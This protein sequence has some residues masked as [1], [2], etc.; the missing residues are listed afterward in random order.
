MKVYLCAG[1]KHSYIIAKRRG[2]GV[3]VSYFQMMSEKQFE[4]LLITWFKTGSK[5]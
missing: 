4:K 3:L 5:K 2:L 1:D